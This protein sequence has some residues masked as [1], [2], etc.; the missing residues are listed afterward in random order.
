MRLCSEPTSIVKSTSILPAIK[1][2]LSRGRNTLDAPVKFVT[3]NLLELAHMYKT[4][5]SESMNLIG[6][7]FWG[8]VTHSFGLDFRWRNDVAQLAK[9]PAYTSNPGQSLEFLTEDGIVQMAV[10]MLPFFQNIMVKCGERGVLVLMRSPEARTAWSDLS[11]EPS[12][13]LVVTRSQD[14]TEIIILKHFPALPV[15][16]NNIV[17]VTGAGDSFVGALCANFVR[18]PTSLHSLQALDRLIDASQQAAV[19]S[20]QSP[21][22][23]SPAMTTSLE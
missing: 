18:K 12:K 4:A 10:S 22:A 3:P 9:L 16:P 20:L 19:L 7:P 13:R 21:F 11:S 6:C 14:G 23:V 1:D 2:E 17:N 8:H 5:S 15:K